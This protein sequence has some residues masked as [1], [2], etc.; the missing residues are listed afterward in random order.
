MLTSSTQNGGQNAPPRM[1]G[2]MQTKSYLLIMLKA[3]SLSLR[4]SY[5]VMI[6]EALF[7][8]RHLGIVYSLTKQ[9]QE[10]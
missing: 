3:Y 8:Q 6:R 2:R 7:I 1:E 10:V 5:D 4:V 9:I